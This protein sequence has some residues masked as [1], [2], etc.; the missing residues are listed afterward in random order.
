MFNHP[1][2]E[3]RSM[4][5]NNQQAGKLQNMNHMDN[6]NTQQN[7]N[8]P[9]PKWLQTKEISPNYRHCCSNSQQ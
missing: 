2:K 1:I 8:I 6:N 4:H 3:Q 5:N 9:S 7:I